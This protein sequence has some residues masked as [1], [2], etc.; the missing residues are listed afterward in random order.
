MIVFISGPM[1]SSKSKRVEEYYRSATFKSKKNVRVFKPYKD[2][3]DY[4]VVSSRDNLEIE[5][6]LIEDLLDITK[7]IDDK[8]TDIF[9]DEINL[10]ENIPDKKSLRTKAFYEERNERINR[11]ILLFEYLNYKRNI[12]IFLAGLNYNSERK[13]FGIAPF[14]IPLA[15]SVDNLQARCTVC[16]AP[17]THTNFKGIK[18][19][20]VVIGS[21]EYEPLCAE[22]WIDAQISKDEDYVKKITGEL[23]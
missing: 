15:N 23:E 13:P 2:T 14:L 21:D 12:N 11:I 9:I 18:N 22:H 3:R 16:N 8:T 17:A 1:F 20:E 5:A 7:Y 19:S 6:I 10:F 4:G